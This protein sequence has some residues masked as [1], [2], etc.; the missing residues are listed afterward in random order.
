MFYPII[1]HVVEELWRC[2]EYTDYMQLSAWLCI[3]LSITK[4]ILYV[5]DEGEGDE[6]ENGR[7]G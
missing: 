6:L 7:E 2:L 1:P 3:V 4:K 5:C